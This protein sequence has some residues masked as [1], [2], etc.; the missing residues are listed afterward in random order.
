MSNVPATIKFEATMQVEVD[1]I[2]CSAIVRCWRAPWKG[3]IGIT[4]A[5]DGTCKTLA[6]QSIDN[7]RKRRQT[8]ADTPI[9][10]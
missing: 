4:A 2:Y 6:F 9:F 10:G 5:D 7:G 3:A 1:D 8:G